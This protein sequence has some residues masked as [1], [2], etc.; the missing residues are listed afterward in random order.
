MADPLVESETDLREAVESKLR[1]VFQL[2]GVALSDVEVLSAMDESETPFVIPP[3][4]LKSG[5][6]K[7]T[8]KALDLPQMQALLRH[9]RDVAAELA[10]KLFDGDTAISP[11]RESSRTSCDLCDYRAVCC[12]ECE[13]P[14][15][16]FRD[17]PG[18]NMEE[19]REALAQSPE[20]KQ[21]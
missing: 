12:F 10:Q 8:A 6:L 19:L 4:Y 14:D 18:M 16:P 9:A 7:K 5:Q 17:L 2:R 1:E 20:K 3:M 13:S 21:F 15:A 11:I